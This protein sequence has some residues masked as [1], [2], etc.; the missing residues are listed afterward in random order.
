MSV[1]C[2]FFFQ[3]RFLIQQL[4]RIFLRRLI[5]ELFLRSAQSF[6]MLLDLILIF[7]D[8]F[9]EF[10]VI[11]IWLFDPLKF[12]RDT[13]YQVQLPLIL[14]LLVFQLFNGAP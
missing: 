9:L 5:S 14:C 7:P 3:E 2:L 8:P 4:L 11:F 1:F 13:V 10:Y 6:P 12:L